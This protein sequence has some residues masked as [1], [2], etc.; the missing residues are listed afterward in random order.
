MSGYDE[1]EVVGY[2]SCGG[3]PGQNMEVIPRAL[4]RAGAEV[5]HLTTCFLCGVPPC[6]HLKDFIRLIE[7]DTGLPVR[8][9]T[10]TFPKYYFELH[11]KLGDWEEKGLMDLAK[12][13]F[14][15]QRE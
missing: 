12:P 1:I 7:T 2:S 4:K 15:E 11:Q 13:L 6:I 8:V 14:P 10:H 3:C 9:G 5:I